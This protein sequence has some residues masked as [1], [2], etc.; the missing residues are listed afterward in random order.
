ML[1]SAWVFN[2]NEQ[3][4]KK[5][6]WIKIYMTTRGYEVKVLMFHYMTP[7]FCEKN[8]HTGFIASVVQN[9]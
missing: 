8:P 1:L 5:L 2:S 3:T 9:T 4:D 7:E 6:H